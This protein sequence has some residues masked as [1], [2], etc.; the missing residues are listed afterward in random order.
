MS[1][2]S[3]SV[4]SVL[5]AILMFAAVLGAQQAPAPLP[6]GAISGVVTDSVTKRPLSGAVV[7]IVITSGGSAP[8]NPNSR[9]AQVTDANGRFV[10][11]HLPPSDLYSLSVTKIGYFPG[12]YGS[13]TNFRL[14]LAEGQW[15]NDANIALD[16]PASISGTVFDEL[17]VPVTGATV[18]LLRQF[19]VGGQPQLAISTG[20]KTDD[21]GVYRI[22]GLPPGKFI[23][24]ILNAQHSV[25]A[26]TPELQLAGTS[27]Q[28]AAAEIARGRPVAQADPTLHVDERTQLVLQRSLQPAPTGD[29]R[30]MAYR[31][32]YYPA[33]QSPR[34]A[35][36]ISLSHGDDRAGVDLRL[37]AVPTARVSGVVQGEPGSPAKLT[38]RLFLAGG[39]ET[40]ADSVAT[41]LVGRDGRFTFLNVP[42]GRYTL[43]ARAGS[44]RL[45]SRVNLTTNNTTFTAPGEN[46]GGIYSRYIGG[47]LNVMSYRTGDHTT[48]VRMPLNVEGRDLD[49]VIVTMQPSLAIRGRIVR[50]GPA[51]P[52]ALM[53]V[54]A[55]PASG[56]A[57][58]IPFPSVRT[59]NQS[60][61]D[62]FVAD[63]LIPGEYVLNFSGPAAANMLVKSIS[64]QG[65]DYTNR[66]LDLSNGQDIANVVATLTTE[67]ATVSGVLRDSRGAPV[68]AATV[69]VF[70]TDRSRWAN[71]GIGSVSIKSTQS[72]KTG[73]YQHP[74]L[75]AGEYF[76]ATVGAADV[77]AWQDP[78]VL[79]R[80]AATALRVTVDWGGKATADLVGR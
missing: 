37:E 77:E 16:R 54:N 39:E 8:A 31:S 76:V 5:L 75:P 22:G 47:D 9:R 43:V 33:A 1:R 64:W 79:E 24:A 49:D 7:S 63:G 34:D 40:E 28:V 71:Y 67:G 61:L 51:Q 38:L 44:S 15:L 42:S 27:E 48:W 56:L 30:L 53:S 19:I 66:P 74:M 36:P 17:G 70:P 4:A 2:L 45:T 35:T 12:S 80:L 50:E 52:P 59:P 3:A 46:G 10:F 72:N 18:R 25:P 41:A 26:D 29:G 55:I 73:E 6:T 69:V 57:A 62:E 32:V 68:T 65:Q 20:A 11:M 23:P 78:R 13:G 21:R 14:T 58:W 60:D